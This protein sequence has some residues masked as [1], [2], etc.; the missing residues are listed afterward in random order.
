VVSAACRKS[1]FC[2]CGR[3]D[4]EYDGNYKENGRYVEVG[5]EQNGDMKSD[6]RWNSVRERFQPIL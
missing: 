2:E 6:M 5:Q 1:G 4:Q 3:S